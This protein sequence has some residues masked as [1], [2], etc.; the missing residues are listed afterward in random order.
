MNINSIYINTHK[1]KKIKIKN[2]IKKNPNIHVILV[3][4][5]MKKSES[6]I[7]NQKIQKKNIR[8]RIQSTLYVFFECLF[9]FKEKKKVKKIR[10]KERFVYLT[11]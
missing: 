9:T 3:N 10:L 6:K 11:Y 5:Y 7:K 8:K 2:L 1:N 4:I